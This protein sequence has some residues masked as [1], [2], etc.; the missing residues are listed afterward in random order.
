[1]A[2]HNTIRYLILGQ[3]WRIVLIS[4]F[5]TIIISLLV[6]RITSLMFFI[7]FFGRKNDCEVWQ[8]N[9]FDTTAT[10][11]KA[12]LG[13]QQIVS[14]VEL[15]LQIQNQIATQNSNDDSKFKK[16]V[17]VLYF[18]A[19]SVS[20]FYLGIMVWMLTFSKAKGFNNQGIMLNSNNRK[21]YGNVTGSIFLIDS[22]V[23]MISTLSLIK[24]LKRDFADSL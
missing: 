23:L 22:L 21:I 4:V 19:F 6:T 15:Q 13:V 9:E 18:S 5:Y 1:M 14:M 10:Y 8:A 24:T 7:M 20:C 11:L 3:R 2:I 17:K 12:I 16:R